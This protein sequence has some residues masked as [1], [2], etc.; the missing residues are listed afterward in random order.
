MI[1]GTLAPT[2]PLDVVLHLNTS[3]GFAVAAASLVFVAVGFGILAKRMRDERNA[4]RDLAE[5]ER[6]ARLAENQ[7]KPCDGK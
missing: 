5:S 7:G 3:V 6:L 2:S 4:F 1:D